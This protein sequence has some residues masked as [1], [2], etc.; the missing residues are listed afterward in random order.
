MTTFQSDRIIPHA[1]ALPNISWLTIRPFLLSR[2]RLIEVWLRARL[3]ILV[4]VVL[5]PKEGGGFSSYVILSS[6]LAGLG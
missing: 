3:T 6:L 2:C 1:R 5:I 4:C